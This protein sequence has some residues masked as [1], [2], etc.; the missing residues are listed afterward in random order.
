MLSTTWHNNIIF[1]IIL[2][3]SDPI[4]LPSI[5]S[6]GG[7]TK[8]SSLTHYSLGKVPFFSS[9]TQSWLLFSYTR[10]DI[11]NSKRVDFTTTRRGIGYLTLELSEASIYKQS[12]RYNERIIKFLILGCS[13][14]LVNFLLITIFIELLAFKSYFLKNLA[15]I[16]AVELSALYNFSISRVWT[17]KDAPRKQGKGLVGQFISFNLALLAGILIRVI[18]FAVFEKWGLFYLLNV[19]I[20]IGIAACID[21][22]LYDKLVFRRKEHPEQFGDNYRSY[23]PL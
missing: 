6:T 2:R 3:D 8:K 13:A 21:F 9:V 22:V 7:V 12:M 15:N 23:G 1:K 10:V 16:L 20:G 5:Q 4:L 11:M 19:A 18:L 17:W 14:A